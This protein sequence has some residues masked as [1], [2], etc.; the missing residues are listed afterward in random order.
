MD[1]AM[2]AGLWRRVS[3]TAARLLKIPKPLEI[4]SLA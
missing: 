3:Q 1:S 4:L 2:G